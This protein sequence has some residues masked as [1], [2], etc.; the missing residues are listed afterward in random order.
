MSL[1]GFF[2]FYLDVDFGIT[3]SH[4]GIGRFVSLITLLHSF[5]SKINSCVVESIVAFNSWLKCFGAFSGYSHAHF[6][7][8]SHDYC[9][10]LEWMD[11]M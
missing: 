10:I 2:K 11:L 8:L 7:P 1:P 4:G 9:I 6:N 3:H 5:V